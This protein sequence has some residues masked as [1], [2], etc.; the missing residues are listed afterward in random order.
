MLGALDRHL[1]FVSIGVDGPNQS[2]VK[3][4]NDAFRSTSITSHRNTSQHTTL[5]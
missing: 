4:A 5:A 1:I 3:L 2:R